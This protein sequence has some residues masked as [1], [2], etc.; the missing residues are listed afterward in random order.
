MIS[1]LSTLCGDTDVLFKYQL[2]GEDL[3]ALISVTNDDDLEHMMHEY[4]RLY[5]AYVKPAHMRL[6][7]FSVNPSHA[8]FESDGGKLDWEPLLRL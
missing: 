6:F 7:L 5:H 4:D 1:K 3:D 2:L 8:S